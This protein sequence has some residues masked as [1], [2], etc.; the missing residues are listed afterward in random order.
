R[1][2]SELQAHRNSLRKTTINAGR[3]KIITEL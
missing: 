3:T 1:R 2:F